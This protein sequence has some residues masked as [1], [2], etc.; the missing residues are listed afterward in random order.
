MNQPSETIR[1]NRARMLVRS[2]ESLLGICQGLVADGELNEREVRF[3]DHWLLEHDEIRE[4]WPASVIAQH[5]R[6][7]VSGRSISSEDLGHLKDILDQ[8]LGGTVVDT[9]AVDGIPTTLPLDVDVDI[10]FPDRSFCFTGVFLFGSRAR[11]QSAVSMR[12]G[13]VASAIVKVLDYVVIGTL[14]SPEWKN[15][16]YGLKIQKAVSYRSDGLALRIVSE[17][18]WCEALNG[19]K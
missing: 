6:K 19:T 17:Q 11:C 1:F 10:I 5:V 12:G 18:Q 9:G 3:L 13:V 15:S 2:C 4:V 14:V 8:L 16:R 7:A